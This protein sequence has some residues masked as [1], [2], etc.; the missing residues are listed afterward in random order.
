MLRTLDRAGELLL[1]VFALAITVQ[2]GTVIL[3]RA[4]NSPTA[5]ALSGV[6]VVGQV[7]DSTRAFIDQT[8]DPATEARQ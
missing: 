1:D 2:V 3:G 5:Y 6:P 4:V 8:Y 7:V